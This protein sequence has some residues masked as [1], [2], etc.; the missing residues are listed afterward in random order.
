HDGTP[1]GTTNPFYSIPNYRFGSSPLICDINN[2]GEKDI[3]LSVFPETTPS[4]CRIL[5]INTNGQTLSGWG[6]IG[7]NNYISTNNSPYTTNLTKEIAVGDLNGDGNLEVVAVGK[8]CI[9]IWNNDG[10]LFNTINNL[11]GLESQFR[12]P[13]LADIDGDSEIEII[14]T[15]FTE[16][17]IHGLKRN[18]SSVLGFPLETAQPFQDATP[19]IADLD[20]NGK[21]EIVAGTGNDRKIYI[22]E[23]NGHSDRIEWG[24]ARRDA[25]NTG[26]YRCRPTVIQTNTVWN[27][28][29]SLCNDLIIESGTLTINSNANVAMDASS[30]VIVKKDATLHLNQGNLSNCNVRVFPGGNVILQNN[31]QIKL[32]NGGEWD[33]R[34]GAKLDVIYGDIIN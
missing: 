9:K 19:V 5:A 34:V 23:T 16:G 11:S 32:R 21:S 15:S 18:G 8:D 27:T 7:T 28:S 13:V 14:V 24:S 31:S 3:L 4:S 12:T 29:R 6:T 25:R 22:W 1:F 20:N 33:L 17:K 10:T 30:T 2:D 26:E